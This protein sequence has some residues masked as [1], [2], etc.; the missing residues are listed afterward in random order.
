MASVVREVGD[1]I[2]GYTIVDQLGRGGSGAVYKVVDGGGAE[3]A[4]KLV[5]ARA[6]DV[7]AERLAREV[8]SL[9]S[10]DHPA[11]PAILDAELDGDET[12]VVFEYIPGVSLWDYIQDN[13]PL[14]DAELAAFAERTASALEAVHATGSVHRDV[15]PSN[16]MMGPDGPVLIDFGLAH[17]TT[18]NRLTRDGL[19][20][21][22]AGYVAPEVIDGEE[23]GAAADRWSWA[24]TVAYA[25]TG[26]A[27]F[28]SGT[29]AISKTLEATV[30]LPDVPGAEALRAALGR[31]VDAR[32]EPRQVV[33]ALR[34][35]TVVL[36]VSQEIPATAVA[37]VAATSVMDA[38][39]HH[40]ETFDASS[41]G[42]VAAP[43]AD[44]AD[45]LA[46][47]DVATQVD[48]GS[49]DEAPEGDDAIGSH[50]E[51]G[52]G[53]D[54][55]SEPQDERPRTDEL[56]PPAPRRKIMIL[57][58][59]VATAASAVVAPLIAFVIMALAAIVARAGQR[60]SLALAA[61][62]AKRGQRRGDA[63]LH[64][65]GLPWHLLR[66]T[67]ESLPAILLG[68]VVGV[69]VGTLGW[70]LV[71]EEHVATGSAEVQAWGQAI[72]LFTGALAAAAAIWWGPWSG[73]TREGAHRLA[74]LVA[75]SRGP[76]VA[77]VVVSLVVFAIMALSV[78]LLVEPMWWPLNGAPGALSA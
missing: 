49:G 6:D 62:R 16:I 15:T 77:W 72:A 25:M 54:L 55:D 26:K 29:G 78:Y 36:P 59:T 61:S 20:S 42:G 70:W 5:D 27:P 31:D 75:P 30:S 12:F 32:P 21:G 2:G 33:A 41:G 50:S 51:Y 52:N 68:A 47:G 17:M 37:A 7:A 45:T 24:A 44:S 57:A 22:T 19:V 11:V 13:G 40:A 10:M 35:D 67:G 73:L 60:R 53:D 64:T 23:P 74:S 39:A 63:A 58:L 18:D 3:A 4:L 48:D 8:R 34:G 46:S 69:G 14:R 9:Q 43:A 56:V 1:E 38:H 65:L 66:A 76:V 28:G 71:V